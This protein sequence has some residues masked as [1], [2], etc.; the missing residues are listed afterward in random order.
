MRWRDVLTLKHVPDWDV[1]RNVEGKEAMLLNLKMEQEA[2]SDA[3]FAFGNQTFLQMLLAAIVLFVSGFA[4]AEFK[5]WKIFEESRELF[6]LVPS[7]ITL[8]ILLQLEL[9]Y[10]LI[11]KIRSS[12]LSV[13]QTFVH[14]GLMQIRSS[15]M[16]LALGLVTYIIGAFQFLKSANYPKKTYGEADLY[17]VSS[18]LVTGVLSISLGSIFTI[19]IAVISSSFR[20]SNDV[21]AST[22]IVGVL[23]E[24]LADTF[25]P[26][27]I[28]I[29][30]LLPLPIWFA[31]AQNDVQTRKQLYQGF[32]PL[33]LALV[34]STITGV[35][36]GLAVERYPEIA[37]LF[38]LFC[39]LSEITSIIH[40][41]RWRVR[42]RMNALLESEG[43]TSPPEKISYSGS[44]IDMACDD[45][46]ESFASDEKSLLEVYS[47]SINIA[48]GRSQ[49]KTLLFLELL[50]QLI[51]VTVYFA[52]NVG[53]HD[54]TVIFPITYLLVYGCFS[55]L[56]LLFG[57]LGVRGWGR[58]APSAFILAGIVAVSQLMGTLSLIGTLWILLSRA[59]AS[60]TK[61]VA[62]MA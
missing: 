60:A 21:T 46:N 20:W 57:G 6:V 11:G 15:I 1:D 42:E 45:L 7:H 12:S 33:L 9:A 2:L 5:D 32:L 38:P 30:F 26:F 14:I 62:V 47:R 24:K 59:K 23:I 29:I 31:L 8:G 58:F 18:S 51:S 52:F 17:I 43:K 50:L 19:S 54:S 48:T 37:Q 25:L 16:S 13:S 49:Y 27:V 41:T 36:F 44:F 3:F 53:N 40:M 34:V 4:L 28:A 61:A 55:S 56:A 39:G 10:N 35:A 22:F